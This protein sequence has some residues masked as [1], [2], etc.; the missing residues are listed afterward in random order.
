MFGAELIEVSA[1]DFEGA[2][3]L[4]NQLAET[5]VCTSPLELTCGGARLARGDPRCARA[6]E[7]QG[8]Q[9]HYHFRLGEA[10][11]GQWGL[12]SCEEASPFRADH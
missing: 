4:R 10:R 7:L 9:S 5:Q 6:L 11:R 12:P 8:G 3:Q 1:G 2:I